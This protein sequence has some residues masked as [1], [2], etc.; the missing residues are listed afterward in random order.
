MVGGDDNNDDANADDERLLIT[1]GK[2]ADVFT[3]IFTEQLTK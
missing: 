1:G 2:N 3:I